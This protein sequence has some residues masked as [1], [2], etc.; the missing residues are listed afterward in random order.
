MKT[1]KSL[2][3]IWNILV[4]LFDDHDIK[5]LKLMDVSQVHK[6]TLFIPFEQTQN[7]EKIPD[8]PKLDTLII[9]SQYSEMKIK[10]EFFKYCLDF[11]IKIKKIFIKN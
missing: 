4:L 2:K 8:L 9:S 6:L 3:I 1:W 7:L 11:S 5:R 10:D